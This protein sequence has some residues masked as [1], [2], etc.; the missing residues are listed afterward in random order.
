MIAQLEI[1]KQQLTSENAKIVAQKEAL[2]A[3]QHTLQ[4]QHGD[5]QQKMLAV[6][7]QRD[8]AINAKNKVCGH[9]I[10]ILGKPIIF[11]SS[12]GEREE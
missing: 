2:S 5:W 8:E 9:F 7:V 11:L 6:E 3:D 10:P 12:D 1:E 4:S